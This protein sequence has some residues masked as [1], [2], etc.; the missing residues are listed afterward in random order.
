MLAPLVLA[1]DRWLKPDG[2]MLPRQV[3]AWAALVWNADLEF[4][5]SLRGGRLYGL[6]LTLLA[7]L[8][9]QNLSW[10]WEQ[11]PSDAFL[12]EPQ[13]MW[14]TDVATVS[15]EDAALPMRA[16]LT[17]RPTREARINALTTWFSAEFGGG[18]TL[19]NAPT[20][21]VTHW[22]Q[23]LFPLRRSI[24]VA[25]ETPIDIEF[26]CIPAGPGYCIFEGAARVG[27]GTWEHHDVG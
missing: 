25:P 1:R 26:A 20:A 3:T 13:A 27:D 17:F 7:A 16:S 8:R 24:S 22:G 15:H 21:P 2:A 11:I 23:Y 4:D 19:T 18:V 10:S 6:D 12:A 9:A 14:T 5:N